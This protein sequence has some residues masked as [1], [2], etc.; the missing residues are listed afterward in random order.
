ML[1]QVYLQQACLFFVELRLQ[2]A[3]CQIC[4]A[5]SHF[6][7]SQGPGVWL[8]LARRSATLLQEARPR[9]CQQ[10]VGTSCA[11]GWTGMASRKVCCVVSAGSGVWHCSASSKGLLRQ[12]VWRV[13]SAL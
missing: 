8:L 13:F 2:S 11:C 12:P 10:Q 5:A 3:V 7:M 4:A 6:L 1:V 9:V